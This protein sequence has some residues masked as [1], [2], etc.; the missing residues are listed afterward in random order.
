MKNRFLLPLLLAALLL[1]GC[2]GG[3]TEAP[4]DTSAEFSS[5][6][7]H[8]PEPTAPSGSPIPSSDPAQ[9]QTTPPTTLETTR[10]TWE[11]AADAYA[12]ALYNPKTY[13]IAGEMGE[14]AAAE[15]LAAMF[16][17]DQAEPDPSRT[18]CLTEYRDLA[19]EVYPASVVN[20]QTDTDWGIP[21]D[22]ELIADNVWLVYISASFRFAGVYAPIGP[23]ADGLWYETLHQGAPAPLLLTKTDGGYTLFSLAAQKT[24]S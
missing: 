20:E 12:S 18:F 3:E 8:T 1:A 21:R 13:S 15:R 9:P 14:Q 24:L 16:L 4:F 23:P 2:R 10:E 11:T 17:D 7:A 19:V 22:S 5:P 6:A